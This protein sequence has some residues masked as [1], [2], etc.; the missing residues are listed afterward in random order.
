MLNYDFL[1]MAANPR[2]R[3]SPWKPVTSEEMLKFIG[4]IIHTRRI[5]LN[6]INYYWKKHHLFN[7]SCFSN[8]MGRD[9]YLLIMRNLH[10]SDN[11][12]DSNDSDR[13]F[14]IRPL[15]NYFNDKMN[16]VYYPGKELSLDE[17]MV[18]WRGCFLF[19]I[20]VISTTSIVHI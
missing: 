5:Q 3:I 12:A 18:L 14:K 17:S 6:R 1:R 20:N 15:I 19:R 10:F 4:L 8:Y 11:S 16:N 2:S 13:L 7:L 9:H